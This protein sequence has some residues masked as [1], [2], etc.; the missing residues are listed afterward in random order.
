MNGEQ[1]PRP[2]LALSLFLPSSKTL[3]GASEACVACPPWSLSK[4]QSVFRQSGLV[5][6]AP[7]KQ[8]VGNGATKWVGLLNCHSFQA[9]YQA[10]SRYITLLSDRLFSRIQYY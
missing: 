6:V 3:P 1:A 5:T 2:S 4:T 10:L 8:P 9:L 7:N